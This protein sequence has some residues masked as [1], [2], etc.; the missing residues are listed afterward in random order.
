VAD[1]DILLAF[2]PMV[3][4]VMVVMAAVVMLHWQEL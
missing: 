2:C 1:G 4:A 3:A